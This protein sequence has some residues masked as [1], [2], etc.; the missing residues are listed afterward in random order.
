MKRR[1]IILRGASVIFVGLGFALN[2]LLIYITYKIANLFNN[3]A[4]KWMHKHAKFAG[5][6]IILAFSSLLWTRP[7]YLYCNKS[8]ISKNKTISICNHV[9]DFD[10]IYI[11]RIYYYLGLYEELFFLLKNQ[12]V[13]IP[14][15]GY[16]LLKHGHI[17]LTRN[18]TAKDITTIENSIIEIQKRFENFSIFIFPEG[19]YPSQRSIE[20]SLLFSQEKKIVLDGIPFQPKNVLIPKTNGFNTLVRLINPTYILDSTILNNPYILM[21]SEEMT[22]F[23]YLF[24]EKIHIS[25]IFIVNIVSNNKLD[26]NFIFKSFDKKNKLI[27]KYKKQLHTNERINVDDIQNILSIILPDQSIQIEQLYITTQYKYTVFTYTVFVYVFLGWNV[28][29]LIKLI[30]L[31][32]FK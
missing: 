8:Q 27:E 4:K 30:I 6:H 15:V 12:L 10:W 32:L 28:Y 25:P 26:E 9:C 7:F 31:I 2:M 23:E 24:A 16:I 11:M 13:Q 20:K 29:K 17:P 1:S 14:L 18:N 5:Y 21:L 22:I 19:T 3:K